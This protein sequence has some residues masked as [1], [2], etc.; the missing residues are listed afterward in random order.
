MYVN[1]NSVFKQKDYVKLKIFSIDGECMLVEVPLNIRVSS[2]KTDAVSHLFGSKECSK[3]SQYY[4][5]LH[6]R[7]GKIV[8]EAQTLQQVEIEDD[9]NYV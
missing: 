3:L 8:D 5:L 7:C 6:V 2:L 4:R 9:G 1:E